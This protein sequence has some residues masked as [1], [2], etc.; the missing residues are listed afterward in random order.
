[1]P[2]NTKENTRFVH[3]P[4]SDSRLGASVL[5]IAGRSSTSKNSH[6]EIL[7]EELQ[8]TGSYCIFYKPPYLLHITK[9]N[10]LFHLSSGKTQRGSTAHGC[11]WHDSAL[12]PLPPWKIPISVYC[13]PGTMPSID[14]S[15]CAIM[16]ANLIK[17]LIF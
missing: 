10:N 17:L 12:Q 1:M 14:W 16:G 4:E 6:S 7:D 13:T 8:M 9:V 11:S 2:K 15:T 5:N 3:V